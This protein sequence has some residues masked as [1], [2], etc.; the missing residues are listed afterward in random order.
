MRHLAIV[1]A[2]ALPLIIVG[3]EGASPKAAEACGVK[4]SIKG[5]KIA[6]AR[7]PTGSSSRAPIAAGPI[8]LS[9]RG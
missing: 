3:P 6:R 4:V 2:A 7:R 5:A 8:D 1:V 9:A